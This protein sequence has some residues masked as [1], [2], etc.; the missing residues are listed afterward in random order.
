ML[1]FKP[2]FD[3]KTD[4]MKSEKTGLKTGSKSMGI[5]IN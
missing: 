4:R 3:A 1:I 5:V 2:N